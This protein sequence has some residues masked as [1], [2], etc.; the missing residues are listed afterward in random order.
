MSESVS[1][2]RGYGRVLTHGPAVRPFGATVI[3]RLPV[4]MT[5]LG[6]VMVVQQV[7]G[8]YAAAGVVTGAFALAT[9]VGAPIWGRLMDRHG[10]PRILLPIALV[11]GVAI[12]AVALATVAHAS[13]GVLVALAI[14]SGVF[15]PPLSP[16]MRAAWRVIYH[17][18]T[19][20]RFGYALDASAVE[21]IFVLGPLLLSVL[22]AFLP[23]VVPLLVSASLLVIGTALYCLTDAARTRP[24]VDAPMPG[25]GPLV[26][27]AESGAWPSVGAPESGVGAKAS[28]SESSTQPA[29]RL[30][31]TASSSAFTAPGIALTLVVSGLMAVGFGQLD[32]A[33]VATA[34]E[35]L[36][37]TTMLGILFGFVAGGSCI[38]GIAYGARS[39]PGSDRGRLVVLLSTFAATLVPWPFLLVVEHP[40]LPVLFALLFVTGLTIAPALIIFQQLLDE[41]APPH[42]MTEAQSLLSASQTT[43]VAAGMAIAGFTIDAWAAPGGLAGA[44]VAVAASA[45][46][47]GYVRLRWHRAR[48]AVAAPALAATSV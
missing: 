34:D 17:D 41:L 26:G 31:P 16:A 20:R 8:L 3:G 23:P 43:G 7:T 35:V 33:V 39:W 40:P 28:A 44:M 19:L 37:S 24:Q 1:G 36:G 27:P 2:L 13:V 38:G 29:G 25:S 14:I 32:T 46:I 21:L 18:D 10:Q 9:A 12:T 6:M 5:G 48:A 11:S 42:Q 15:F 4:G 45:L 22:A 30:E 47:A